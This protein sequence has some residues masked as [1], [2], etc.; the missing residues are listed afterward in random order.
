MLHVWNSF[1]RRE[2]WMVAVRDAVQ[3]SEALQQ[4]LHDYLNPPPQPVSEEERE[5]KRRGNDRAR[6]GRATSRH[7]PIVARFPR[8]AASTAKQ[9]LG[10]RRG[11]GH[12]NLGDLW[13]ISKWLRLRVDNHSQY[14]IGDWELLAAGFGREVAEAARD[15][16]R[17]FWRTID[18]TQQLLS[19]QT[20][21]GVIVALMGIAIEA[22]T[23]EWSTSLS[24]EEAQRATNSLSRN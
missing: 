1:G 5:L 3:D 24:D 15:G 21:N 16:L 19:D 18:C 4:I 7:R 11:R 6:E 8:G 17:A 13:D 10:Q 22:R 23:R 2:K 20:P 14:S 12:T 9:A